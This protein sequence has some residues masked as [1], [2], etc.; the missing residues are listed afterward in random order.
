MEIQDEKTTIGKIKRCNEG[1]LAGDESDN[2]GNKNTTDKH[3]FSKDNVL[4]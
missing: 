1:L 2:E 4:I 3:K